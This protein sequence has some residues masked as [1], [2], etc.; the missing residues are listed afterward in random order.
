LSEMMKT[1]LATT[2]PSEETK[3]PH[4][5]YDNVSG[6]SVSGVVDA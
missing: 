5:G 1:R 4:R 3:R 2:Y 6:C